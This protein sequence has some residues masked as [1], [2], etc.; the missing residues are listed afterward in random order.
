MLDCINIQLKAIAYSQ[1]VVDGCQVIAQ[2]MVRYEK[3]LGQGSVGMERF[4]TKLKEIGYQGSLTIEREASDPV[5]RLRDIARGIEL[6]R[7]QL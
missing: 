1:L 5:E 7:A 2:R 3:P 4:I 6:L